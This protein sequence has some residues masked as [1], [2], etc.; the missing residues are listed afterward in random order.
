M[1]IFLPS[2][3]SKALLLQTMPVTVRQLETLIRLATAMAKARMSNF[4]EL[5]DAEKAFHLLHYA[6]FKEIP[7]ERLEKEKTTR[8][9]GEDEDSDAEWDEEQ[10]CDLTSIL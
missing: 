10:A 4:V 8:T 1:A 7:R 6:C 5:R 9:G 3:V 2:S